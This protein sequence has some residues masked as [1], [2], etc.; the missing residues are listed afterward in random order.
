MNVLVSVDMEGVAGVASR[1][2][3][4]PGR[5][6]YGV[7]RA[8]M[9]GEANAAAAGAFDAGADAVLVND[10]HG[11]MDNLVGEDL[12][13]RVSYV[14]GSPKPL[15]MMEGLDHATGVALLVGYH[16]GPQEEQGVL[17][18]AY[19]GLAFADLLLNGASLTEL[20]LNALLAA[21]YGVPIGL[22]TGDDAICL[23]AEKVLPGVVTVPVKTAIGLTAARSL[24]PEAAR[25]AVCAG[26]A[27]AVSAARQGLVRPM[28]IPTEL[29]VEAELR[30]HGAAEL[31]ARVPGTER[32]GAR[33]VRSVVR[34]PHE[35]LDVVTVWAE[36]TAAYLA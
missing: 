27:L 30:P 11:P 17:A 31:V 22:V 32:V 33:G 12:D 10:S 6:D 19:S 2:Q 29:V 24:H 8:L 18:H 25:E 36:L 5:P 23:L 9:T 35:L 20:E 28:A 1:G 14:V 7:G 4:M 26:A 34:D 13:R 21:A 16:A 15:V 3:V